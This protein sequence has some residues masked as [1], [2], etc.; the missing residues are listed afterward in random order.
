MPSNHVILC[1]LLLP[2]PSIFP[3]IRV[4]SN[5]SVLRI[6]WPKYWSFIFSISP[7]GEYSGL[8]SFRMDW[9]DLLTVQGALKSL[10]QHC[11]SKASILQCSAFFI[12]Q[13]LHPYMTTGKT[14]A[15]TRQTF[16]GKIMFLLFNMLSRLVITF[17]PWSKPPLISW[18]Q[19]L[20]TVIW[21]PSCVSCTFCSHS[22]IFS[23]LFFVEQLILKVGKF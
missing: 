20:S 4:F 15:L 2:L 11:C 1:H 19:P 22:S 9:L 16:A 3:S 10:L 7:S 23:L 6:R 17:L 21:E 8:T 12:I 13:C 18:R 14:T 5:E